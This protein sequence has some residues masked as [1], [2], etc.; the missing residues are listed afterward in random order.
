[1]LPGCSVYTQGLNGP[2][3][4]P[5]EQRRAKMVQYACPITGFLP[6]HA[7]IAQG[8]RNEE[9]SRATEMVDFLTRVSLSERQGIPRSFPLDGRRSAARPSRHTYW[10]NHQ[11]RESLLESVPGSD[12]WTGGVKVCDCCWG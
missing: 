4:G 3:S 10:Y 5:E 8:G 2:T 6:L 11:H 7:V 12:F 9:N 1:M